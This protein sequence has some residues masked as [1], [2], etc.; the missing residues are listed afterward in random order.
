MRTKMKFKKWL[1]GI[2][3]RGRGVAVYTT[4]KRKFVLQAESAET[5]A[6]IGKSMTF[7]SI[8]EMNT[9]LNRLTEEVGPGDDAARL[10][11]VLRVF[12]EEEEEEDDLD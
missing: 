10:D 6:L 7:D 8:S 12:E 3:L 9:W 11:C 1:Y 4:N 5:G 2:F